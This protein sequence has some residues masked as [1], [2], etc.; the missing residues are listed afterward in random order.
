MTV[1]LVIT[2]SV[3]AMLTLN[4]WESA[5][6]GHALMPH[7]VWPSIYLRVNM[8]KEMRLLPAKICGPAW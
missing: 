5:G 3:L 4:P 6:M 1:R 2:N 7:L 8:T